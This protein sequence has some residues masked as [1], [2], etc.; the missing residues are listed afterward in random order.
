MVVA[1]LS[2]EDRARME[3]ERATM[4]TERDDIMA[5]RQAMEKDR[6]EFINQR[7][8]HQEDQVL[9]QGDLNTANKVRV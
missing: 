2:E 3:E 4:S 8:K 6:E 7:R 9:L 5:D 1:D